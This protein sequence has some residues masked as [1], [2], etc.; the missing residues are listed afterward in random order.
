MKW[1]HPFRNLYAAQGKTWRYQVSYHEQS[2]ILR[3]LPAE[4]LPPRTRMLRIE[5]LGSYPTAIAAMTAGDTIED[6]R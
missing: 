5:D 6:E 4:K 2:W 3:R 1:D